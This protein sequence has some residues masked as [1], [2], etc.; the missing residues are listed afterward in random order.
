[1]GLVWVAAIA[2]AAEYGAHLAALAAVPIPVMP[3]YVEAQIPASVLEQAQAI[4]RDELAAV[5]EAF[6]ERAQAAGIGFEIR[7][8]ITR[9]PLADLI[10]RHARYADLAILGQADENDPQTG[11]PEFAGDVILGSGRPV[12]MV[13]YI[14]ALRRPGRRIMVAWDASREAARAVSDALPLLQAADLVQV[15]IVNP[16]RGERAHGEEPG[17]DIA[18]HLARHGVKVEVK[19][20][21]QR[22][23]SVSDV[24]LARIADEGIDLL[25]LGAYGHARLRE[26]MLGGVTRD[27]L[28]TMTVPLFMAH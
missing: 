26:M 15:L 6:T 22:D 25:V 13:P 10:S 27:L 5:G 11:D 21:D 8:E 28:R 12:L 16:R 18:T 17:A 3:S 9:E 14:G 7:Q 24:I 19:V 23:L 1:M 20:F 2:F 4:L